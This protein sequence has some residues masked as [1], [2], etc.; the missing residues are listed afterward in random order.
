VGCINYMFFETGFEGSTSLTYVRFSTG[1]RD[2]VNSWA[3]HGSDLSLVVLKSCLRVLYG[4][5]TVLIFF[6]A[7]SFEIR[8]VVPW[9]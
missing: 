3:Q 7:R 9:M 1:A 6:L 4:L 8:S 5:N 2:L